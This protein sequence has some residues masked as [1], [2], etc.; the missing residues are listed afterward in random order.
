MFM[1]KSFLQGSINLELL[2]LKK[3]K[4]VIVEKILKPSTNLLNNLG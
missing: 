1:R 3:A 2:K 4:E